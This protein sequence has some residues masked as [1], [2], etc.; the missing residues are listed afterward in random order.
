MGASRPSPRD[1]AV[2]PEPSR[3][4]APSALTPKAVVDTNVFVS[5]VI[6]TRGV[7]FAVLEAW[8]RGLFVLVTSSALFQE[9]ATVLNR[10][11]IKARYGLTDGSIADVL[12]LVRSTSVLVAPSA[13]LPVAVRDAK[14]ERVLE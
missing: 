5:G 6:L 12:A 2:R 3:R 11:R 9:L 14:D 1:P 7:P 4:I 10:P 8:R 13:Q